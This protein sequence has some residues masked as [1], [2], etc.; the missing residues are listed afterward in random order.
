MIYWLL[1]ISAM[2]K[3]QTAWMAIIQ[4][5][6]SCLFAEQGYTVK[7]TSAEKAINIYKSLL[8]DKSGDYV[9]RWLLNLAYMV[10]GDYPEQVPKRWFIPQ[11]TPSDSITFPEFN[12]IAEFVGLDHISLAGGS[13]ADDFDGDGLIDIMVSS[14]GV[15]D[16]IHYFKNMGGGGFEDLTLSANLNGITGGLN[17]VHGD[18][19][20]DG[21][22][23]VLVLR[24]GWFE[25]MDFIQIRY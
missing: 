22:A 2:E 13:I 1:P 10:K 18:Y 3:K 4:N 14:W 5:L 25:E 24:G 23:D 19:N 12:E 15:D 8:E 6:V 17:M 21:W 9:Y 7:K 20:N 11:L 16:Q